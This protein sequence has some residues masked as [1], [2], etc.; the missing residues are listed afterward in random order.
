MQP[1]AAAPT[2][3]PTADASGTDAGT[4]AESAPEITDPRGSDLWL[5]EQTGDGELE[6]ST[7]LPD[8]VSLLL[9]TDGQAAAPA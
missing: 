2:P 6:L 7:R 3:S 1:E 4:D 5:S 9:A 8:D